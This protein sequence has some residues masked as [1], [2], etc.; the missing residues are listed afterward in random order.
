[1]MQPWFLDAKLGIFVHWGIYAVDGVAES[2]SWFEG[3][4]GREAY[5]AQT[6]GF[7]A[8][9]YDP[10]A[11]ADLF[12]RAGARYAVLTARHHDGIALWD[13][14]ANPN[15]VVGR[16]PAGRDLIGPYAEALR[17]RGLKVGLYYSHLD[18]SHPD[19]A[20]LRSD[21]AR[22]R[23]GPGYDPLGLAFAPEGE[24]APEAWARF[25]AFHRAEIDEL[26]ER[27]RPDLWWFDG[28]WE[29]SAEEWGM[30]ELR[31]RLQRLS[32]GS[33]A[34]GRLTGFGDYATP[35]QGVPITPPDGPW[36]FCV[37]V[38]DSW[39]Y[40]P[41]DANWKGVGMLVRLFAETIGM[42]GN[43]LLDVGPREDG[44]IPA[45]AAERLEGLGAWIATHAAAVY[46]TRAGLPPGLFYGAST[47][48]G[49]GRELNLILFDSPRG[50]ANGGEIAV[51]GLATP[52]TSARHLAT[53]TELR[54][55]PVGG[56][57]EAPPVWW[58]EMPS[59]LLEEHAAV[60]ALTFDAPLEIYTG[61]GRD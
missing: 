33:V 5:F 55:R 59:A 46:G 53:G 24:E 43:M 31:D 42:G 58:I 17:A 57:G 15:T 50:G 28:E 25:L 9:R 61:R 37:T 11:W 14:D 49:D 23:M 19:Y 41:G 34:N 60:V 20:T 54:M 10:G 38:N 16:T 51:K 8:A 39:G 12:V 6:E 45:E 7:T 32:P 4:V 36:E 29:R 26:G 27:V 3:K 35:E 2:W 48:S 47:R 52:P 1:M 40:Q 56:M 21:A 44:T 18:W 30:E 13:S 22:E